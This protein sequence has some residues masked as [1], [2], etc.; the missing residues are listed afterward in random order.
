MANQQQVPQVPAPNKVWDKST[1]VWVE[2][3]ELDLLGEPHG[4]VGINRESYG[5][6]R[7]FVDPDVA[8]E[9]NRALAA[10]ADADMRLFRPTEHQ[11]SLKEVARGGTGRRVAAAAIGS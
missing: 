9:L 3:P 11:G 5:P 10:K 1:Y 6:G 8:T 2:I 7:H 4:G